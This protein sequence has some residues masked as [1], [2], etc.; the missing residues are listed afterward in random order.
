MVVTLG[1]AIAFLAISAGCGGP[2]PEKKEPAPAL[3]KES[4]GSESREM[5]GKEN[6]GEEGPLSKPVL[7]QE[8]IE[9]ITGYGPFLF[10]GA[11]VVPEQSRYQRL[12]AGGGEIYN[13]ALRASVSVETAADWYKDN[14]EPDAAKEEGEL[15]DGRFL[16]G[17][18]YESPDKTWSKSITVRGI[19]GDK[20]CMINISL[21]RRIVP[22]KDGGTDEDNGAE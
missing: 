19:S 9:N 11:E 16:C 22:D 6:N 17:F 3:E 4:T 18:S 15:L 8:D 7:T 13:L 12:P 21:I 1:L 10:P 2:A 14:L 20:A 5:A